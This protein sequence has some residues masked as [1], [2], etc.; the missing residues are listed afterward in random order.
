MVLK[1]GKEKSTA[2]SKTI[3]VMNEKQKIISIDEFYADKL[4][5][6][7]VDLDSSAGWELFE[8]QESARRGWSLYKKIG[9]ISLLIASGLIASLLISN[10]REREPNSISQSSYSTTSS[11]IEE[12]QIAKI[13]EQKTIQNAFVIDNNEIIETEIVELENSS[14]EVNSYNNNIKPSKNNFGQSS[15]QQFVKKIILTKTS[16]TT[17]SDIILNNLG[18][19]HISTNKGL[20]TPNTFFFGS[21]GAKPKTNLVNGDINPTNDK[22]S[23]LV[24][25]KFNQRPVID[26]FQIGHIKVSLQSLSLDL[27][28]PNM[29][30][31]TSANKQL[32]WSIDLGLSV[33]KEYELADD[34]TL[35]TIA[36]KI[37][38]TH[39]ALGYLHL[40][41]KYFTTRASLSFG[42]IYGGEE[43]VG[44]RIVRTYADDNFSLGYSINFKLAS[45]IRLEGGISIG[46]SL[47]DKIEYEQKPIWID[48]AK[49][50]KDYTKSTFT[51]QPTT[52]YQTQGKITFLLPYGLDL[53]MGVNYRSQFA[54][55]LKS[56]EIIREN[57]LSKFSDLQL[58][59][60]LRYYIY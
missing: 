21:K 4:S 52:S 2:H 38:L 27:P 29:I 54:D 44:D 55:R 37:R 41:R 22:N 56:Q 17:N 13:H 19:M 58:M 51:M 24:D 48:G 16:V 6:G 14:T 59:L 42:K 40:N 18:E 26:Y 35:A 57:T 11:L 28:S 12:T 34:F 1:Q 3:Y 45:K 31:P 50:Y 15:N 60:G 46:L 53:F 33:G 39:V 23:G 9:T 43:F 49:E 32:R 30:I 5:E 25:G 8:Q 7:K 36:R 20:E 47:I 10:N